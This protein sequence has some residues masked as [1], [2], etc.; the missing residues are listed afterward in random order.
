MKRIWNKPVGKIFLLSL[1]TAVVSSA[2]SMPAAAAVTEP[3][4]ITIAWLP[5]DSADAMAGMRD[6]IAKAIS[7][8]TGKKVEN[9][10]TTD[11][12]IAIAAIENGDAQLGWF[13][14]NEYLVSHA[15][16][17]EVVPLVVNTGPSGTLKDALYHSRF[18][19]KKGNEAQYKSG[20]SYGIDNI[21]GKRVS[22][23]S[24][25]STSGFVMPA[26]AI[27]SHFKKNAKWKHLSNEE[28]AQGGSG[29]FFK[30]V[31]FG[32]S[33]QLSLVNALTDRSDISA[34]C[35]FLVAANVDLVSGKD[36]TEGAVYK[37]KQ[38]ADAPFTAVG[39][40]EFVIIKSIAVLNPPV[41]VNSKFLSKKT[42]DAIAKVLTS[43]EVANNPKIFAPAGV[44][45]SDFQRPARF[46]KVTD[47]WYDPMRKV[48]GIK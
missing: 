23:V 1:M 9:K 14:A 7:Q 19:V 42:M 40:K 33:H 38:G 6:E 10:L 2:F 22:F 25:S 12:T 35:D 20:N 27:V 41:E 43:D 3:D 18:V 24:T 31:M 32:G 21:A 26:A 5:N 8:A 39:G 11:Y 16:H 17:P 13:G 47:S 44:K 45:G 46:V 48:L 29:K 4:T 37:V 36:N 34:V 28:L 30:Q 15:K